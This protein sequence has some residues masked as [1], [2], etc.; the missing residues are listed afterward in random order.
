[1]YRHKGTIFG[2]EKLWDVSQSALK[3]AEIKDQSIR[4][5]HLSIS[6]ILTGFLAFEG[7]AN[8]VGEEIAP[9]AWGDREA[10]KKFF[11][12]PVYKGIVGKVDYLFSKF[13]EKDLKKGE[14]LYQTFKKIKKI[15]DDLA[16]NRVV[17]FEEES[18]SEYPSFESYWDEFDTP[19]KVKSLLARL[20]EFAE[21]IRV[22]AEKLLDEEYKSSHLH[23][24][25]FSGHLA[26]SEG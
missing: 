15:R 16:H 19:D 8:F 7:F 6:S 12:G 20:K 14:K 21:I 25:V 5:N 17:E 4:P 13:P 10:E 26:W 22:E 1:M 9:E 18:E 24:P 23:Y 3:M 2:Y 11:S